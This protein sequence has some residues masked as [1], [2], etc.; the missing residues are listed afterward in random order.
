MKVLFINYSETG[1]GAE[2]F[3][4]DLHQTIPSSKILSKYKFDANKIGDF[5]KIKFIDKII[6][7]LTRF[8][9][10]QHLLGL[11]DS[12]HC[13]YKNLKKTPAYREAEIIHLNNIHGGW[14]DLNALSRIDKE[15]KVIWTLHDMW[16]ITGGE[17]HIFNHKGYLIGDAKTPYIKNYPLNDPY[18]DNRKYYLKARKKLYKKLQN[19][20]LVTVSDWL[21]NCVKEAYVYNSTLSIHTIKNGV[22]INVF[23][24]LKL[25][26]PLSKKRVLLFNS[27]SPF[28]GSKLGIEVLKK[29]EDQLEIWTIGSDCKELQSAKHISDRINDRNELAKIY[30]EIDILLFPSLAENMPLTILEAMA[31]GVVVVATPVGGIP[32]IIIDNKTGFLSESTS[33]EDVSFA[34]AKSIS[35]QNN[36]ISENAVNFVH[37]YHSFQKMVKNYRELYKDVLKS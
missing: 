8:R 9:S 33:L 21:R 32:E 28:K 6:Q 13:T 1:G 22:D 34:F 7:K 23:R 20:T 30:N 35:L 4:Y 29:F 3:T 14:F 5:G 12:F 31:C 15:K 25:R 11:H 19:T 27:S 17:A 26:L 2:Q 37:Q 16:A 24:N 18:F 36:E 10:L